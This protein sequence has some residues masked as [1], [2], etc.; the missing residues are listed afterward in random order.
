MPIATVNPAN[1]ETLRTYEAMGE[2]EIERRIELAEATFRTYRTTGFYERAGLMRRAADLLEADQ[3]EIG[4]VITTEMGKPVKQARAEAAKCAKA[5]RW[6]ADHAAELLA[7]EEPDDADV[8]DSGASRA[9]VR[10]RPLGPVLAVM[11]WNFPLWQVIRFAAPALMAGNVGLLKHASN[12]PQTALYLEDLFHRAGFPE[13]CFQTLLIGSAQVDDVLRDERVRAATLTGSEPAGRAVASTAGEMIKKTVLELGG[14]DPFVVMPSADVDRA[15]EVAVTARTQN[16][17]Q[18]CIAA[19]R[20]IVHTDVYDAFAE[21]FTEGMRAL[22]VGDPMDEETEVGPLSS[23]Q[24]L[25]DVV[26]LVD[27]AVRGGATVLC[28][29]ERPDGPGWYYPPTVLA[30]VTRDLRIHRE[31]AFGPVATLYR[32]AD[33]DEAVLIANDTDFGLSSNVWTRDDADVDRF[34]RDLEA[35]GVYVNGMTASH[36]AFPFGGVKRSGY[37]RELSGHGIR[38]FC[39][40]TTVWHGA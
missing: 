29:G 22:R 31:E 27:D 33:L 8:K 28:G 9:L 38:E 25:N 34:V 37:G 18:S 7:D 5:M 10:Y 30:D 36:P 6:Y 4:K 24:G 17:G 12:V 32:A 20:F 13:G 35:G 16:A 2:E 11:P 21:R 26:E 15:A 23:E 19:K 1:G 3:K 14:S 39:N 40:I